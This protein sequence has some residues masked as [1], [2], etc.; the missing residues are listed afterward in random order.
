[1]I[2]T[3]RFQQSKNFSKV[4][5][6]LRMIM[7]SRYK[8]WLIQSKQMK[9][10][11]KEKVLLRIQKSKMIRQMFKNQEIK[12]IKMMSKQILLM[13]KNFCRLNHFF[14]QVQGLVLVLILKQQLRH[15]FKLNYKLLLQPNS[16]HRFKPRPRQ[17]H[18]FKHKLWQNLK[19]K[20]KFK[21]KIK[22]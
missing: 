15:R 20:Q 9:Q 12:K 1:M 21:Y 13:M 18:K 7:S 22:T 17:K 8:N 16:K 4:Q 5:T 3:M 14:K 11:R 2:Q 19:H 6:N 10:Q